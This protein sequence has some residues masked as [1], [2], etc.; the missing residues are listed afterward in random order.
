MFTHSSYEPPDARTVDS[1]TT[2]VDWTKTLLALASGLTDSS[3]ANSPAIRPN[4]VVHG[5]SS[6]MEHAGSS[7]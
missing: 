5:Q 6:L 4:S 3:R 7:R 2:R 1:R